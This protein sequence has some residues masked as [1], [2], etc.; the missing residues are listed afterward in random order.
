MPATSATGW[1]AVLYLAYLQSIPAEY[2][3]VARIDG[4]SALQQF[5]YLT[6][7]LLTPAMTTSTLLLLNGGLNVYALPVALTGGGPANATATIT[8]SIITNG[9]SMGKYGQA[10]ALAVIYLIAVG[11]VVFAQRRLAARVERV[12][13]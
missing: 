8:Q 9:V 6:L 5:R 12:V 11:I 10:S 7:P 1:H 4:A 2:Y 13:A 3:E